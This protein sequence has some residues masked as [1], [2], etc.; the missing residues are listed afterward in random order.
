MRITYRDI[1]FKTAI[2]DFGAGYA[3]LSL[4]ARF[5][6]DI[7]KIDMDLIRGIDANRVKQIVLKNTL[8]MLEDLGIAPI[9]EGIETLGELA[10]VQ[11]LGVRLVQGYVLA[12]PLFEHP[13]ADTRHART[14]LAAA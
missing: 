2:D 4:L 10:V 5:Q 8:A 13:I 12:R 9:C 3:G 1:G 7:V 11:D 14:S 6:P